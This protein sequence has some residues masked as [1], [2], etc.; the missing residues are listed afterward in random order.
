[1][2]LTPEI[3]IK[4]TA[5]YF[6]LPTRHILAKGRKAENVTARHISM[7]FIKKHCGLTLT[8][9]GNIFNLDHATV[10]YGYT[11]IANEIEVYKDMM[12]DVN[13]IKHI[14]S[15]KS[16]DVEPEIDDFYGVFG[17]YDYFPAPEKYNLEVKEPIKRNEPEIDFSTPL[18]SPFADRES[19][20]NR[21][22]SGYKAVV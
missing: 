13:N 9:I 2:N 10:I 16:I 1:M 17:W 12:E 20:V 4:T 6:N 3:I 18:K 15:K 19:C 14:L 7:Y 8:K 5:E 11:R 21:A 22:Y